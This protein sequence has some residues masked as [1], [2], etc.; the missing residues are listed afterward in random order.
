MSRAPEGVSGAPALS[1]SPSFV[2]VVGYGNTIRGDD[3]IGWRAVQSL[4]RA[5]VPPH[6]TVMSVHQL[7]PELAR[8][9]ADAGLVLFIDAAR[10]GE[11]GQVRCRLVPVD[12][13]ASD[14]THQVTPAALLAL[15][16]SLYGAAPAAFEITMSGERF[17]VHEGLSPI[18][19]AALP[20]L[21]SLIADLAAAHVQPLSAWA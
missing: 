18:C 14:L 16:R 4:E 11:P 6:V 5:G 19:D 15:A 21:V 20:R 8:A 9:V 10:D 12:G 1:R 2:L 13:S 7:G 3:G 17:D